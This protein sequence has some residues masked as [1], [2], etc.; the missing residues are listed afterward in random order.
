MAAGSTMYRIPKW[1]N[2]RRAAKSDVPSQSSQSCA[3]KFWRRGFAFILGGLSLASGAGVLRAHGC[4]PEILGSGRT[5]RVHP[6]RQK[7][8]HAFD[9]DSTPAKSQNAE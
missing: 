4:F 2:S 6:G 8:I 7:E 3:T 5:S 1:D 9:D